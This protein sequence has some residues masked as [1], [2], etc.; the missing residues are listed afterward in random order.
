M[1]QTAVSQSRQASEK[2]AQLGNA[3]EE[4]IRMAGVISDI[5][6]QTNLLALNATIE[7]VRHH[8]GNCG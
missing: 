2:M 6:K 1:T 5:S 8:G 3:T 7:A 4:I